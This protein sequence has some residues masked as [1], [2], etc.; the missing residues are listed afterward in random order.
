MKKY[1]VLI[2]CA[3]VAACSSPVEEYIINEFANTV[4]ED[5]LQEEIKTE[6]DRWSSLLNDMAVEAN[7]VAKEA[8]ELESKAK[9]M[10]QE[11]E[12]RLRNYERTGDYSYI[13]N[14][15]GDGEKC[16][17]MYNKADQL[18][19][20]ARPYEKHKTAQIKEFSGA[21]NGLDGLAIFHSSASS[22]DDAVTEQYVLEH[23]VHQTQKQVGIRKAL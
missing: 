19:R 17:A 13:I 21:I 1:F 16:E 3:A 8:K 18:S 15:Y 7:P 11:I 23:L 9:R 14:I 22:K 20:K 2:L 4:R 6:V 12:T 5:D 10:E